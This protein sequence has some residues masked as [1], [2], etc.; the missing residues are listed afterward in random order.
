MQHFYHLHDVSLSQPSTVTVGVFDGVHLGHQSLLRRLAEHAHTHNQ[1]AVVMTFFPH[2]DV[3]LRGI[4]ERYYLTTVERR[5]ALLGELGIDVVITHP[6]NAETRQIRATQFVDDLLRHLNMASLWATPDFAL[7][8]QREGNVAF[9]REQGAEKGF[10]VTTIELL[11]DREQGQAVRSA[12]IRAALATGDVK[13]VTELLGR[14][15]LV[16]GKVIPGDK[17]GRTIGFPTANIAV[18][19]QQLLPANGVYACRVQLGEETFDAVT[20]IGQRP[21]FDGSGVT[22]ETH[23]LDFDRDIYDQHLQVAFIERLRGEVKFPGIDAL[24][25]QISQDVQTGRR[26]LATLY[27]N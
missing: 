20:N 23:L 12:R 24:V 4:E 13:T 16:E 5:A 21:T 14:P 17:R 25:A 18:W 19:E 11:T 2:P 6:F 1:L 10:T 3:V 9:L 27:E 7:G 15:Y 8:Y 26:V 22:V